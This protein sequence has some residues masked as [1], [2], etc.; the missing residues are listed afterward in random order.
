M[1][2]YGISQKQLETWGMWFMEYSKPRSNCQWIIGK[3]NSTAFDTNT[4][5]FYV[6]KLFLDLTPI[7]KTFFT[8]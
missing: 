1:H 2:C 8:R 7:C 3:K 5:I 6:L 4:T